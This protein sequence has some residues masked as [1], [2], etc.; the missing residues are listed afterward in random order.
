MSGSGSGVLGVFWGLSDV[1]VARNLRSTLLP[2]GGLGDDLDL[3]A[4]DERLQGRQR[5]GLRQ[6]TMA[7]SKRAIFCGSKPAKAAR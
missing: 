2:R 4:E 6:A 1:D 7:S 5:R 3:A